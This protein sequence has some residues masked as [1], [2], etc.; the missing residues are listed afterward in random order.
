MRSA[1]RSL[2]RVIM[3]R[4]HRREEP[5]EARLPRELGMERRREHVP[6]AHRDDAAVIET[7]QDVD[8][9]AG[10]LDDRGADEDG[11]DR[12]RAEDIDLEVGL[13]GV[14]LTAEGIALHADVEQRE[15]RLLA[16]RDVT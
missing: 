2:A 15:D 7:R 11:M 5:V 4:G 1:S 13:E 3:L 6:L 9:G 12:R 14:E 8:V 16:T 10:R